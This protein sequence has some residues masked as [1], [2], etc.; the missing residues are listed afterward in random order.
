MES[1]RRSRVGLGHYLVPMLRS[2]KLNSVSRGPNP[3]DPDPLDPSAGDG[4]P[5]FLPVCKHLCTCSECL[6]QKNVH[7]RICPICRPGDGCE[8]HF[9]HDCGSHNCQYHRER[10]GETKCASTEEN[11]P[12]Q[13]STDGHIVSVR[14]K[15]D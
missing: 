1:R 7:L 9:H 3:L 13:V 12:N 11:T 10:R 15:H 5:A 4:T 2:E 6:S 14:A 8:S